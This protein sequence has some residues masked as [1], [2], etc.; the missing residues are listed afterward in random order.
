MK[1]VIPRQRER[2]TERESAGD[3][4][5]HRESGRQRERHTE[6]AGDKER[7]THTEIEREAKVKKGKTK[8]EFYVRGRETKRRIMIKREREREYFSNEHWEEVE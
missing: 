5:I 1:H 3:R 2:H 4:E 6:R 8:R 7:E